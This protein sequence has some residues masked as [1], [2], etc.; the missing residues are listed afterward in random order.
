MTPVLFP[1]SG[2]TN[3]SRVFKIKPQSQPISAIIFR[4]YFGYVSELAHVSSDFLTKSSEP[5]R[6][7]P[8]IA[9]KNTTCQRGGDGDG[10]G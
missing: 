9:G 5:L 8:R 3:P 10:K 6:S 4:H 1:L 2:K 7:E